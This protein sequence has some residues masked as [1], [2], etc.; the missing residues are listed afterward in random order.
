MA[1]PLDLLK[2]AV[3][4]EE[5]SNQIGR[6]TKLTLFLYDQIEG[7]LSGNSGILMNYSAKRQFWRLKSSFRALFSTES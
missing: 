7:K 6:S 1:N 2:G 4:M 5:I 3:R